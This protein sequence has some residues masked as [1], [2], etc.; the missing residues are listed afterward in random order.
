MC[1]WNVQRHTVQADFQIKQSQKNPINNSAVVTQHII[2][3]A[4][5]HCKL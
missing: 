4:Y 2:R 1:N 3:G 5:S